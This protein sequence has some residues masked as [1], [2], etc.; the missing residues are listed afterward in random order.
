ML[1]PKSLCEISCSANADFFDFPYI[2][3]TPAVVQDF[4]E[5]IL[6]IQCSVMFDV[7]TN[8]PNG[9]LEMSRAAIATLELL[10]AI[11]FFHALRPYHVAMGKDHE[12][13]QVTLHKVQQLF[14]HYIG[15][16]RAFMYRLGNQHDPGYDRLPNS[17]GHLQ[18]V[19]LLEQKINFFTNALYRVKYCKAEIAMLLSGDHVIRMVYHDHGGLAQNYVLNALGEADH[20]M[21]TDLHSPSISS[22][23]FDSHDDSEDEGLGTEYFTTESEWEPDWES[24][25]DQPLQ[26]HGYDFDAHL[27]RHRDEL[28][29]IPKRM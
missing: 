16:A 13:F 3:Y 28:K 6:C 17:Q 24:E 20:E 23:G 5:L 7:H 9:C 19:H 18:T 22:F 26:T 25:T 10:Q 8:L 29:I 4:R 27:Q 12:D 21:T 15:V 1:V 14:E 11:D 2:L